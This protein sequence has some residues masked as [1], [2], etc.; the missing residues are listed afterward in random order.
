M[1]TGEEAGLGYGEEPGQPEEPAGTHRGRRDRRREGRR[2][3]RKRWPSVRS[4]DLDLDVRADQGLE[5]EK[6]EGQQRL[7]GDASPL[8]AVPRGSSLWAGGCAALGPRAC[9]LVP[10]RRPSGQKAWG[11][12]LPAA[13]L[14]TGLAPLLRLGL[15]SPSVKQ[16]HAILSFREYSSGPPQT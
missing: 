6:P 2:E 5:L 10:L 11:S 9:S 1:K 3:G 7:V 14:S 13:L 8:R 12:L 4:L 15:G 16:A